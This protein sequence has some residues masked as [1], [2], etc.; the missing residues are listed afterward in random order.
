MKKIFKFLIFLPA[1]FIAGSAK[2]VCPVCV[3]AVGA[4]IGLSRWLGV[5]DLITGVWIGG[6]TVSLIIWTIGWLNKKNINFDFKR[7]IV[8]V[9]YYFSILASLHFTEILWHP[10]NRFLGID[11]IIFG[12]IAG[13]FIFLFSVRLHEF[14]KAKNQ[15][16]SYFPYQKV[17]IP[18]S[19]LIVAS[20]IFYLILILTWI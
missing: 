10:Q 14:L 8:A 15:G 5:D 18:F 13:S 11:K 17:I 6:L 16:K 4:G 12:I 19:S 3:V 1:L 7:T 9:I 20:F 2:A